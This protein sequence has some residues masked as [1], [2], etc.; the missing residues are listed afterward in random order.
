MKMKMAEDRGWPCLL[1]AKKIRC[2]RKKDPG[3][4]TPK[5]LHY[6]PP[7]PDELSFLL[8]HHCPP[9]PD[10]ISFLPDSI[11]T[12]ILNYLPTKQAF[13][14]SV[15]S[16]NWRNLCYSVSSFKFEF[17]SSK[18]QIKELVDKMLCHCDAPSI[19]T[20]SIFLGAPAPHKHIDEWVSF[21]V[22]HHVETFTLY[23]SDPLYTLPSTIFSAASLKVVTLKFMDIV[24]PTD[25]VFLPSLESL[26][27]HCCSFTD[28]VFS[29]SN[30]PMLGKLVIRKCR[31]DMLTISSSVLHYL[32]ISESAGNPKIDL[33]SIP[34][35]SHISY[36]DDVTP[37]ISL[38]TLSSL[39]YACIY[40]LESDFRIW[41]LVGKLLKGLSSVRTLIVGSFYLKHVALSWGLLP[42]SPCFSSVNCLNL[43]Y[44]GKKHVN[45]LKVV[46]RSY[47]N[48]KYLE[49]S[50]AL[51][52][53]EDDTSYPYW[54]EKG[55]MMSVNLN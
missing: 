37:N 7:S 30:Y 8:L 14:T 21:A 31:Y 54:D 11:Q 47:P 12:L 26:E 40:I 25:N 15:L 6:C 41:D 38:D 18:S 53:T 44:A 32:L 51:N 23:T 52:L 4:G 34:N 42:V 20:L 35:L 46:L 48:L 45:V 36:R 22:S 16:K 9:P 24:F 1:P 3:T 28:A 17:L 27:L 50:C 29:T 55:C 39:Q 33:F 49:M 19:D 10:R 43:V 5:I 13:R 2:Y